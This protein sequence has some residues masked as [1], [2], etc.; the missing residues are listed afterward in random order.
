MLPNWKMNELDVDEIPIDNPYGFIY[1]ITYEDGTYYYGKKNFYSTVR[2]PA[3]KSGK[4]RPNSNRI[5]KNKNGKRVYFDE[6]QKESN[7][8]KYTGSN[9]IDLPIS[10]REILTFASSKRNLT[11]LE[12]KYLFKLDAL[13]DSNC[14]NQNINGMWFKGNLK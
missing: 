7:W 14:H 1:K 4:Q 6:V 5:G 13:E 8:K 12:V 11:Y 3:L 9:D 10:K 2:L